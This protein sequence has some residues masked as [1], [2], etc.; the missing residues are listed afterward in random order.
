MYEHNNYPTK[1]PND[2]ILVKI[3]T[4]SELGNIMKI[5][6]TILIYMTVSAHIENIYSLQLYAYHS[7]IICR[8]YGWYRS[9]T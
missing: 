5:A 2:N 1:G 9:N 7:D 6:K 4:L 3:W 8:L